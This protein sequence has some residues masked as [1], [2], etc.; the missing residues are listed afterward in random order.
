MTKVIRPS[1]KKRLWSWI[2]KQYNT[3]PQIGGMINTYSSTGVI[4]APL[5]LL[6]VM[7]TVYG[8]WGS[9]FIQGYFPWFGFCHLVGLM[10][11]VILLL[12]LLF[13]KVIIPSMY[14]FQMGQQYLHRNPLV[15]DMGKVLKKLDEISSRLD[16]LEEKKE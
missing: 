16:K 14:A 10:V 2:T 4:Y 3:G 5:T 12:M 13:Y 1:K 8:L 7:T 9:T 6:G 15:K 11:L